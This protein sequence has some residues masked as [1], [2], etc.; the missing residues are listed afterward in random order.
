MNLLNLQ[1]RYCAMKSKPI[2]HRI[3]K[4]V[5]GAFFLTFVSVMSIYGEEKSPK[6][7][8]TEILGKEYYIYEVKKGESIY[9][10]S[11][12]NGWDLEELMRLNPDA[13]SSLAKGDRLYYP[14][15]NVTVVTEMPQQVEIDFS[16]LEPIRHKVKKGETIYSI[17]RQYGVPLDI[18]Y[19]FNPSTKRGVKTGEVIEIPQNGTGQYYFYTVKH[20]DTLSSLAQRYN[21]S[22][23]DILK[24][25][26]GLTVKNFK[27]GETVRIHLNSNVGKV[28]T[29]IVAED[30]VSQIREYKVSK[31]ETWDVI[32]EKTGVDVDLL[33]E[34]NVTEEVPAHNTIINVPVIESVEVEKRVEY[35]VQP[36]LTTEEVKEIYDSIKGVTPDD[37]LFEGVRMALI[38]DEPNSKKDID[39][40]RGILVALSGM[41]SAP[42][43]IDFKVLDGRV[44]T[45]DL[46][47]ELDGYEPN[48]IISTADKAFP[49][50]LADYGNT[51]N[52]QVLNVFDLKNDL[53]EDNA[54][55]VQLLPPSSYFNDR[56]ATQIYKDNKR[57][58]LIGVGE[59]DEN[60]GIG[61]ELF[62]LYD[63]EGENINLE[64]FGSLEPDIMESIVIYSHATK[65][66]EVADFLTNVDNLS[67]NNPGLDF[68]IIGRTNWLAMVD[69]FNDKFEEYN[70]VIPSRIFLNEDSHEWKNFSSEYEEM[71][72]GEPV[73]S[74]PS[75]AAS[76]YDV[77]E[78]FIPLV[79]RTQGDFNRQLYDSGEETLQND[80][81]LQRVNNWGG[82]INSIGYVIRF[83]PEGRNEKIIVK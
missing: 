35:E 60:D 62:K 37:R 34:T 56:I 17:S 13:T 83:R 40:T 38:L 2:T 3:I 66:E 6:L 54:S 68:R 53:Y 81:S 82:F 7:E 23:E 45:G 39:F 76:G 77:A 44:S 79:A 14:T 24:E 57:R 21:T 8:T 28:K 30:R 29:E 10:I 31:N 65:K 50:F 32:S 51:N 46:I 64:T 58:K 49:L 69:D 22:V 1:L 36:D 59:T 19:K 67:E 75:F 61:Q 18:I 43:K 78:Y 55:M 16:S 63:G 42:Y 74:I 12:K 9:G 11:K 80:F 52:V 20:G 48:L 15:G 47:N 27:E 71:F 26:A 33:K 73:R 41:E 25:N 72:G 70:V 4:A 5:T